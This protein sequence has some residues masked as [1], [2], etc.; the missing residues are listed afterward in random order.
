MSEESPTPSLLRPEQPE[1][2]SAGAPRVAA[3]DALRASMMFLGVVLHASLVYNS[4]KPG[5]GWAFK[6][7]ANSW[8]ALDWVWDFVH[9]FRLPLF[10][11][12]AG[13]L[14]ALLAAKRGARGFLKNRLQ[15]I[16][17]P[18]LAFLAVLGPLL[19]AASVYSFRA[20][21]NDPDP[22][23]R[24]VS[25]FTSD[26]WLPV[27]HLVGA[28]RLN[29]V[30]SVG[31]GFHLWF[32]Y[33]LL[34]YALLAWAC[35]LLVK[36]YPT[37]AF[38]GRG[39]ARVLGSFWVRTAVLLGAYAAAFVA[40]ELTGVPTPRVPDGWWLVTD[41]NSWI[42]FVLYGGFFALGWTVYRLA[43][44]QA[45]GAHPW[46]Q[47]GL[48]LALNA[49]LYASDGPR[50]WHLGALTQALEAVS[51]GLLVFGFLALFLRYFGEPSVRVRYL[52]DASYW[53]YLVHLP[54]VCL[55]PGLLGSDAWWPGAKFLLVV[56]VSVGVS[57]AT[58]EWAVRRTRLGLFL[59]GRRG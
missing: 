15:R 45:F 18:F 23:G 46:S 49:V 17:L 29:G 32:L 58:Y 57:L 51:S 40:L 38:W 16:L 14:G 19:V 27:L 21:R 13:Y 59:N 8:V 55:L 1:A 26:R 31:P 35:L 56:A 3:L 33:H 7:L 30:S 53:V 12:V 42:P 6:D 9:S 43:L 54:V 36:R 37:P 28:T 41:R 4:W 52:V 34:G 22:W 39:V 25:V 44:L 10:Y 24:V 47:L 48:G 2:A 20:L 5:P 11:W 50:G